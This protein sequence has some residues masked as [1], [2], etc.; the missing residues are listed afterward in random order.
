MTQANEGKVCSSG[1]C[2]SHDT[3]KEAP[4]PTPKGSAAYRVP[5]MDCAAE[6]SE[7]RNLLA[8]VQGINGLR[9]ALGARTLTITGDDVAQSAAV[10]AIQKAGFKIEPI[11]AA[12]NGAKPGE[13]DHGIDNGF[14]RPVRPGARHRRRRDGVFRAG[15]VAG[16]Q[17]GR[18]GACRCCHIH[19]WLRRL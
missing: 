16:A 1:S 7:I 14:V 15:I 13:D 3:E 9:F 2:G 11:Q 4:Q 17:G 6:E 5:A 10:I 12:E 19:G 8:D 18:H